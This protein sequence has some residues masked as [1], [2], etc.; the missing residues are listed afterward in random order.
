MNTSVYFLLFITW[1]YLIPFLIYHHW[2]IQ[3]AISIHFSTLPFSTILT[4]GYS[5]NV[6][7]SL[8]CMNKIN[9]LNKTFEIN[10]YNNFYTFCFFTYITFITNLS[11]YCVNITAKDIS[12]STNNVGLCYAC[13]M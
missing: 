5:K 1:N 9:L 11:K 10:F 8:I 12:T 4:M 13:E 2:L 3:Y 6:Y 7:T